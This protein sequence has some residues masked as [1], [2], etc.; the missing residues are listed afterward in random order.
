[1]TAFSVDR[2]TGAV[3]ATGLEPAAT[4]REPGSSLVQLKV[5]VRHLDDGR[6]GVG[7]IRVQLIDRNDSPP[8][9]TG[10]PYHATFCVREPN[11]QTTAGGAR[12]DSTAEEAS[13]EVLSRLRQA[14]Q[15]NYFK[16]SR[17]VEL[18]FCCWP[19]LNE[20]EGGGNLF[21]DN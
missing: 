13:P 1:M 7:W 9:F 21:H 8:R 11:Q 2:R 12:K 20:I 17:I 6:V 3:F 18:S 10:L 19:L 4:D 16:V 14:C 5:I 15:T